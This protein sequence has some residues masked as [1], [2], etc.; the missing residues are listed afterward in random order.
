MKRRE[1]VCERITRSILSGNGGKTR[2]IVLYLTNK[3]TGNYFGLDFIWF[4]EDPNKRLTQLAA[5]SLVLC[6]CV[7]SPAYV[8]QAERSKI[9]SRLY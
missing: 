8:G 9:G 6:Y 5:P 3:T 1:G 2:E 7:V 4:E